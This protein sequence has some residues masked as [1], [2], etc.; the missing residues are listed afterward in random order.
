MH[1]QELWKNPKRPDKPLEIRTVII[2]RP[3]VRPASMFHDLGSCCQQGATVIL[4]PKYI[5]QLMD[6]AFG[7]IK[8]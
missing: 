8:R 5:L 7:G 6:P 2:G 1:R 4:T 3:N